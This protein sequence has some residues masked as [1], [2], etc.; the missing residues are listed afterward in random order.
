MALIARQQQVEPAARGNADSAIRSV[1]RLYALWVPGAL[2]PNNHFHVLFLDVVYVD[3]LDGSVRFR[4]V[5]SPTTQA[6]T[7]L[8]QTIARRVGRNLERQGLLECDAE[9]NYLAPE[10]VPEDRLSL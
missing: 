2:N 6:L 7:R 8:A 4:R 1:R 5:S 9:N 3:H 10:A